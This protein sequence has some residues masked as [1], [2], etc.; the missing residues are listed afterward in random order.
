MS[1]YK[2]KQLHRS[3]RHTC[4][5]KYENKHQKMESCHPYLAQWDKTIIEMK[6]TVKFY[7][8]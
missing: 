4:I 8:F 6:L 1:A 7:R 3:L 2:K 5:L